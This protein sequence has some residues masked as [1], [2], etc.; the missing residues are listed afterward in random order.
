MLARRLSRRGVS[1]S[2]GA[3]ALLLAQ[4]SASAGMPIRLIGPTARAASLF[5]AGE[6]ATAGVVP[7]QVA[8]LTGE[9]MKMMLL[10]KIKVIAATVLVASALVAG[11]TGVAYQVPGEEPGNPKEPPVV[12]NQEPPVASSADRRHDDPAA[13]KPQEEPRPKEESK[14]STSVKFP[15]PVRF[16]PAQEPARPSSVVEDPQGNQALPPPT[17]GP[18]RSPEDPL[19]DL[20]VAGDHT[21][22][23][24]ERAKAIIDAMIKLEEEARGKSSGEIDQMIQDK[25]GELEKA[26]WSVRLL[27]AQ[28]RR[29]KV[30][31]QTP[32][33]S[34]PA[35]P[36]PKAS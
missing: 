11:G 21:P 9:V 22:E 25:A 15:A 23:Q 24:L 33:R 29:L 4:E 5:A 3:L 19:A 2:V 30:I 1:L 31:R 27:D 20:I 26:R 17:A 8:A 18:D 12:G 34:L 32:K 6:A 35:T 13:G 16:A 28:L 14:P 10:S 36:A 7:A